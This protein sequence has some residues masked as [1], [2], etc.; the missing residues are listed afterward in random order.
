MIYTGGLES[1]IQPQPGEKPRALLEV[2]GEP[3]LSILIKRLAESGFNEIIINVHHFSARIT[4]FLKS[5]DFSGIRVEVSDET[6]LILDSGGGLRKVSW[7]FDDG[8][9]FLLYNLE[10]L[11]DIDLQKLYRDHCSSGALAT[12]VVRRRESERFIL[13]DEEM[14]MCGWVNK[15]TGESVM[16]GSYDGNKHAYAFS[17]IQIV[18]PRLFNLI[19]ERGAFSIVELYLRIASRHN[20]RGYPDSESIWMDLAKKDGMLEA[21]KLFMKN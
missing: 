6:D 14:R 18:S 7:F 8:M 20:I 12:L 5:N 21:E 17:R 15:L 10:I 19:T 16:A 3:L 4:D 11:S 1:S 9:P 2:N 13:F